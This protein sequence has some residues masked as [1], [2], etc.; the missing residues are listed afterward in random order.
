MKCF[1]PLDFASTFDPA[2]ANISG[3]RGE[4]NLSLSAV[5]HKVYVEVHEEGTEAASATE[6][7]MRAGAVRVQPKSPRVLWADYI[8]LFLI[9]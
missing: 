1:D 8:F 7:A 6:A 9:R 3:M 4:R 5:I 2:R